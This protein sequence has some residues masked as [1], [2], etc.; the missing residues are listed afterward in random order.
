MLYWPWDL[1]EPL[2]DRWRLTGVN[3]SGGFTT[4]GTTRVSKTDG[5]GLWVG[6]QTF[7]FT[8]REQIKAARAIEASLDGGVGQI[9]AWSFEEPFAPAGLS[10][11]SVP[12]SDGTP[13][14]DGSEYLTA[15]HGATTTASADLRA[16]SLAITMISGV[17]QGGE[18]FSI[19]HPVKGMRRYRVASVSGDGTEISIRPPLR[20]AIPTGTALNFL[21]VGC[22]CRLAN[23]EEFL[24]EIDGDHKMPATARWIEAF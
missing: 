2:T 20:E 8:E 22:L 17:I 5:G 21:R 12:H 24:G 10:L 11:E 6:E 4:G 14:G 7:L 13:F 1:L 3:I 19:D 23:P 16:T 18:N 9:V 15:P